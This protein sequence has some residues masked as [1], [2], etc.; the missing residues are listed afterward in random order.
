[1]LNDDLDIV[2]G[3]TESYNHQIIEWFG[4]E[5][6][7]KNNLVLPPTPVPHGQGYLSL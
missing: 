5:G 2:L 1:M 6:N 4:L 7:F 3:Y